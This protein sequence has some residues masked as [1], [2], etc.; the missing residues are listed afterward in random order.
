MDGSGNFKARCS[1]KCK[2]IAMRTALVVAHPAHELQVLGWIFK[3]QPTVHVLTDGSGR[4]GSS[5]LHRTRQILE[6][7][8]SNCGSIFGELS[9]QT[10]YKRTLAVDVDY[11]ESL[12]DQLAQ[13]FVRDRIERVMGDAEEGCI[14]AHDLWR[15]IRLAAID[16]AEQ[17][18]GRDI[19]S[20]DFNLDAPLPSNGL[21]MTTIQLDQQAFEEKMS[22]ARQYEEVRPFVDA[23][24]ENA[25]LESHQVEQFRFVDPMSPIDTHGGSLRTYE[26]HGKAQVDQ[27]VYPEAIGLQKHLLAIFRHVGA[28]LAIKSAA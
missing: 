25:G 8:G 2:R 19:E 11:F 28:P 21:A 13:S 6:Q 23:A 15:G 1:R 27:G 5:R 24:I 17:I 4:N 14:M 3:T 7:T 18:L 16:R 26:L 10:L 22:I 9:D 20:W 12:T